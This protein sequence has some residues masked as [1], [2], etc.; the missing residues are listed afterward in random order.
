MRGKRGIAEDLLREREEPVQLRRRQGR[1]ME[2]T[3]PEAW[4][5]AFV[6]SG[7]WR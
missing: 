3:S 1:K 5:A 7:D 4:W 6:L 2:E